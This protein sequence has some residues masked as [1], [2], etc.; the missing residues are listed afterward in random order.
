MWQTKANKMNDF[1]LGYLSYFFWHF[2]INHI[3]KILINTQS[4]NINNFKILIILK[5]KL[6]LPPII[7]RLNWL[8]TLFD[9][10]CLIL[11][12]TPEQIIIIKKRIHLNGGKN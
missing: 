9:A 12:N 10:E 7:S 6:T 5:T 3:H 11:L 1:I 8:F 4:P 2:F